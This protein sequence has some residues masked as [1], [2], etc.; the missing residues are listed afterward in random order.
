MALKINEDLIDI[1]LIRDG[2]IDAPYDLLYKAFFEGIPIFIR[3]KET[4]VLD[5][6]RIYSLYCDFRVFLSKFNEPDGFVSSLKESHN[7]NL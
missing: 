7:E 5:R 4:F 3:N 2:H 1:M 6:M